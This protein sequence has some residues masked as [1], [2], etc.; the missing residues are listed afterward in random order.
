MPR[1][2]IFSLYHSFF[3]GIEEKKKTKKKKEK[4]NRA[5]PANKRGIVSPSG[6]FEKKRDR[7]PRY[8]V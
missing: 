3:S 6:R 5:E 7:Y 8:N 2:Y 1:L 4:K